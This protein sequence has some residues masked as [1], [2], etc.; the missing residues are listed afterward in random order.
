M[1]AAPLLGLVAVQAR[2]DEVHDQD[3]AEGQQDG[4]LNLEVGPGVPLVHIV[5]FSVRAEGLRRRDPAEGVG[6]G[7]DGGGSWLGALD[8]VAKV[9]F[10]GGIVSMSFIDG[11][12]GL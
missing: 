3:H 10:E 7:R 4:T 12:N 6:D 8:E 9:W 11:L 2:A 1:G 5:P